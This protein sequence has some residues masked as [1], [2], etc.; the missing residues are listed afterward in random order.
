MTHNFTIQKWFWFFFCCLSFQMNV[1]IH[2][3]NGLL[4]LE[5]W[6][7]HFYSL[8]LSYISLYAEKHFSIICHCQNSDRKES[9]KLHFIKTTAVKPKT[10]QSQRAEVRERVGEGHCAWN[11]HASDCKNNSCVDQREWRLFCTSK[12]HSMWSVQE[13]NSSLRP[14]LKEKK[15][16][17]HYHQNLN[18][19]GLEIACQNARCKNLKW[20]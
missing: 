4:K 3:F 18:L 14:K 20:K 1:I 9:W 13:I 15:C 2:S 16:I 10:Q 12:K 8:L 6:N 17:T 5:L 7:T 19:S 11:V